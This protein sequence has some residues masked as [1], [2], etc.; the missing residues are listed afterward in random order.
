MKSY[1]RI[2]KHA[3]N[4]LGI[5][6]VRY[7]PPQIKQDRLVEYIKANN[8]T[9][10]IDV[11]ANVGQF[12]KR[13]RK[14]GYNQKIV[15]IEPI[16][17]VYDRLRMEAELDQKW[18]AF[19]AAFGSIN[20]RKVMNVSENLV[21]SSFLDLE[22]RTI[23]AEPS[24]IYK[25]AEEV[26]V[27]SLDNFFKEYLAVEEKPF[28][29]LDVQGYESEILKGARQSLKCMVGVVLECSITHLYK[30]EWRL[31]DAIDYFYA[32]NYYLVD[33]EREFANPKTGELL[34]V[35]ALFANGNC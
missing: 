16:K 31:S 8:V 10:V 18:E 5:D 1:A 29:K 11:G 6:I 13:I 12:A 21:S 9:C 3:L 27:I 24:V 34:Q 28:L 33:I 19:N 2:V 30:G 17:E 26:E 20:E 25:R 32:N 14:C 4:Q 7:T 22:E 35:N 23:E 15:S